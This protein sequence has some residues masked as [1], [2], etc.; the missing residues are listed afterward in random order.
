MEFGCHFRLDPEPGF[1]GWAPLMQQHAEPVDGAVAARP[2]VTRVKLDAPAPAGAPQ[3]APAVPSMPQ[4]NILVVR[5][6][7][8]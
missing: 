3:A 6:D 1:P 2:R 5:P 4:D 7:V 8:Y